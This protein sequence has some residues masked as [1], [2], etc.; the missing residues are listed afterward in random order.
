MEM[1]GGT[2]R[3]TR[4][5]EVIEELLPLN[6]V[7]VSLRIPGEVSA[8]TLEPQGEALPFETVDGAVQLKLDAFTCHQMIVL[9][10]KELFDGN[11]GK[12]ICHSERSEESGA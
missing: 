11:E 1:H 10:W 7:E 8:V 12:G 9:T 4:P 3:D 2:V 5:I 6:G